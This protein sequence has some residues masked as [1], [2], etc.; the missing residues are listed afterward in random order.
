MEDVKRFGVEGFRVQGLGLRLGSGFNALSSGVRAS[1]QL[2]ASCV[3]G[4]L[5]KV[6]RKVVALR[7]YNNVLYTLA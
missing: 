1:G 5:Y 6:R 2:R 3:E 4:E 7:I